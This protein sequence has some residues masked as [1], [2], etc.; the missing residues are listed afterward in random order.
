MT[1]AIF[2][3]LLSS[4]GG[5]TL[6]GVW[7]FG[8]MLAGGEAV[9]AQD[10]KDTPPRI[11]AIAPLE[12]CP[13]RDATLKIR[14]LKLDTVTEVRLPA[15]PDVKVDVKEKKKADLPN[16]QEAKEVGDTQCEVVMKVPAD[17][18]LGTTVVEVVTPGGVLAREVRVVEA[19][20]LAEEKEPNN[21]F[22][23]AQLLSPGK[24]MRG[25]IEGEKDVDVF[26]F[27]AAKGQRVKISVVAARATSMLDPLVTIYDERGRVLMTVDDTEG[28]DPEFVFTAPAEGRFLMALQDSADRG[29]A[30]HAYE[31][32]IEEVAK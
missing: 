8:L 3:Y 10:K 28:R 25:K 22:R 4:R 26:A 20:T 32:K 14:G 27:T 18:P 24:V 17:V 13:G 12:I 11:V 9:Q 2:R 23:E 29:G 31:L 6:G 1:N 5:R 7:L 30:W 16:G 15:R 21:G 19:A